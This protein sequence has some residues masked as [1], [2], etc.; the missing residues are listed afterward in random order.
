MKS[1]WKWVLGIVIVVAV[2]VAAMFGVRYLVSKGYISLP[3]GL[4]WHDKANR[5][6]DGQ[7][8]PEMF[9]DPHGFNGWNAPRGFDG[10]RGPMGRGRGFGHLG[11]AFM[12]IGGLFRLVVFG[13]L[14]YGAYW[15]G[16]RNARVVLNS[17]PAIEPAEAPKPR[18]RKVAKS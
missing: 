3:A 8:G 6:F 15:L 10:F 12:F 18:T 11:M 16:K 14:L 5:G 7:R 13:A 4:A 1:L 2:I 17:A 9:N